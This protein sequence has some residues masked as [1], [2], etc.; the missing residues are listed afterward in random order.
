MRANKKES[1]KGSNWLEK[2]NRISIK[3]KDEKK[4]MQD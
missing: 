4:Q 2:K 1:R 3:K